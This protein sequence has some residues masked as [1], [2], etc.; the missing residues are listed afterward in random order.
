[1]TPREHTLAQPEGRK[2]AKQERK[3]EGDYFRIVVRSKE[4]FTTVSLTMM[5]VKRAYSTSCW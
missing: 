4:K 3:G 1:M 2:R 5:L